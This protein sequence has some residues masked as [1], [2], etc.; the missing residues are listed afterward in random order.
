MAI[1]W[2]CYNEGGD[3]IHV[4]EQDETGLPREEST[5]S[6]QRA[7][8]ARLAEEITLE[9]LPKR[10]AGLEKKGVIDRKQADYIYGEFSKKELKDRAA[11]E[12]ERRAALAGRRPT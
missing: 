10:L 7:G 12:K 6:C 3:V 8:H 4:H 1:A 11:A 9:D 2:F 5:T